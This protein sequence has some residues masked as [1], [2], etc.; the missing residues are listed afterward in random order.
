MGRPSEYKK[1]YGP[2]LID[3]MKKGGTLESF[4]SKIGHAKQTIYNWFEA[5]PEFLDA[6]KEGEPH[7]HSFYEELGKTIATGQL[8]RLKSEK[9]ALDKDDKPIIGPDG[10]VLMI[11]EYEAA[12]PG[13]SAYIFLTKNLLGWRDK[14]D[15]EVAGKDG[16]PIKFADMS[17]DELIKLAEQIMN[18]IKKKDE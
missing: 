17:D 3:H 6:R 11:R 5:H 7:L 18:K 10:K 2:L 12:T 15:I 14:K 1:E 8:R 9:P 16:G 13:Q 4:G